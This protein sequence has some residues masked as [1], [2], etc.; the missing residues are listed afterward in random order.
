MCIRDSACTEFDQ[1]NAHIEKERDI[2]LAARQKVDRYRWK[3]FA[4]SAFER[5]ASGAHRFT[6]LQATQE[7]IDAES[8]QPP[9]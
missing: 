8:E 4:D 5:G 7:I 6:H 1:V 9:H 2:L 3:R